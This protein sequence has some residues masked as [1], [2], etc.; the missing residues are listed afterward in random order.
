MVQI[1]FFKKLKNGK[2]LIHIII[3]PIVLVFFNFKEILHLVKHMIFLNLLS[4]LLEV[5]LIVLI[6]FVKLLLGKNLQALMLKII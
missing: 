2:S 1:F 6:H 5:M 3:A 4:F